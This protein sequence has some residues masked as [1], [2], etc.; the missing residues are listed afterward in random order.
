MLSE[1]PLPKFEESSSLLP[2]SEI[3]N[4]DIFCHKHNHDHDDHD[5]R[6][7]PLVDERTSRHLNHLSQIRYLLGSKSAFD[8]LLIES[9]NLGPREYINFEIIHPKLGVASKKDLSKGELNKIV[10]KRATV[11]DYKHLTWD[12]DKDEIKR[13]RESFET[14]WYTLSKSTFNVLLDSLEQNDLC[15]LLIRKQTDAKI[16]QSYL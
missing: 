1:K 8:N 14:E 4:D 5:H 9:L 3:V 12:H 16:K 13:L 7:V 11:F 15:M 10:L 2:T 6:H